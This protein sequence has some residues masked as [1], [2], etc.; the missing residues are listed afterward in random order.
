MKQR[1]KSYLLFAVCVA[2][3]FGV[4][5][6]LTAQ[7]L[8]FEAKEADGV[9]RRTALWRLDSFL[10]PFLTQ[11]AARP[12]F[13]YFSFYEPD[14]AYTKLLTV[15]CKGE[16]S[17]ASPLL[18][19]APPF[20]KLHFQ[21]NL[22]QQHLTSP[23]VP[24]ESSQRGEAQRR[25]TSADSIK[26][27]A[28]LLSELEFIVPI[29]QLPARASRANAERISWSS[30][31]AMDTRSPTDAVDQSPYIDFRSNQKLQSQTE[32]NMRDRAAQNALN[33][34]Q[35][36]Q[37]TQSTDDAG[38]D[39]EHGALAPVWIFTPGREPELLLLRQVRVGTEHMV[40]GVWVDWPKLKVA[41]IAQ[42]QDL[43]PSADL[44]PVIS[45][46]SHPE[47]T[48]AGILAQIV[49][50][51]TLQPIAWFTPTRKSLFIAW[52]AVLLSLLAIGFAFH[53]S[54]E[55]G[56]RRGRFV[57][58]V[59]H[60][61]RTPLTTFC[62]YSQMLADGMVRDEG[63]KKEY[64]T[65][66]KREANRL[67]KIVENVLCFAR[68]SEVR[69]TSRAEDAEAGDLMD[70][71]L[72]TLAR[73]AAEAGMELDFDIDSL[74][75]AILHVDPQTVERILT[76]LVDNACKYAAGF[77]PPGGAADNRIHVTGSASDRHIFIRVAD[78]G[79]GIP[80]SQ[81]SK[82]FRAFNRSGSD[83]SNTKP[84]LG[85]GLSLSRGLA[86]ALGGDLTLS[87][88]PAG[89]SG[90]ILTLLLPA[91]T[92]AHVHNSMQPA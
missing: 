73:R 41:L 14:Q 15:A 74:R 75:G 43:L 50:A 77:T 90:A 79:P 6:W 61:L 67:A 17:V 32:Y 88:Q 72:P 13:E 5:T 9:Q 10:A 23:Q 30:K 2:A 36:V 60:E 11:E 63:A 54:M 31:L 20:C 38:S 62:L 92:T 25:Y 27:A 42:V 70:R 46:V 21:F 40:Q 8:S 49:T 65:T 66:L 47:S 33:S 45:P 1:K 84:G 55:L 51:D 24:T 69:S 85:L 56:E 29:N 53:T 58:A 71:T 59:T 4:M 68:L 35:T 52:G 64:L 18:S 76:N 26:N 19:S 83:S 81:R 86:R 78:H 7:L 87:D 80:P 82:I 37:M 48:V 34:G 39:I 3:V 91:E 16:I 44:R 28:S 57:S 12:Y 89:S 22:N